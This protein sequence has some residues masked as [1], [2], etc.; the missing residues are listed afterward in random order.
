MNMART[1]HYNIAQYVLVTYK[2]Y[3]LSPLTNGLS[4]L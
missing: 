3:L 2:L 1:C 4:A